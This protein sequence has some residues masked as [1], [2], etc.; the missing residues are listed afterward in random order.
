MKIQ[1]SN[2][3]PAALAEVK[4]LADLKKLEIFSH[5]DDA[6]AANKELWNALHPPK[7]SVEA[8]A[9]EKEPE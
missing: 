8:P 4:S 3:N 7:Q 1:G 2:I 5:L 9:G 6:D